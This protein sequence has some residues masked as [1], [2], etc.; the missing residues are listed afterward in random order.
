M[1]LLTDP[2]EKIMCPYNPAHHIMRKRMNTHLSKCKRN[3]PESK[4]VEC[5]FNV[6]HKVP[7]PELQYHHENCPDRRK[8]EHT[9]YHEEGVPINK[10][11]VHN[12]EVQADESWDSYDVPSYDPVK[13]CE[14]NVVIRRM[15]VASAAVRKNFRME[16]RHRLN[17]LSINKPIPSSSIQPQQSNRNH[18]GARRNLPEIPRG[19]VA[20][21]TPESVAE[22]MNRIVIGKDKA[23][24]PKPRAGQ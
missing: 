3:Y 21:D 5:D 22:I 24:I 4:L 13:Y 16:E 8:I 10:F 1:D 2:E 12:I 7:E 23:F 18:P 17:E 11:P 6:N 9:V 15:D 14:T 19:T 20:E